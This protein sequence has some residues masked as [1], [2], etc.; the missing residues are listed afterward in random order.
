M[1]SLDKKKLIITEIYAN[2][3]PKS[4]RI[5]FSSKGNRNIVTKKTCHITVKIDKKD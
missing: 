2:E 3:G 5:K 4:K 1:G